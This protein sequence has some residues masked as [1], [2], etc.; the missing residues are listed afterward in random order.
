MKNSEETARRWLRQGEHNLNVT[1][2]LLNSGFWAGA[3]FYAE[4]TAK[5]VLKA[6]LYRRGQ[7]HIPIYSVRELALECAKEDDEFSVFVD[8]GGVLD[9]YYLSTRYPDAVADPA[10]PFET[11][12]E[13]EANRALESAR[14]IVDAVRAKVASD[15]ETSP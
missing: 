2:D 11:F 3:C 4:Q 5:L 6:F 14:A 10:V 12:S 7:R 1:L 13:E 9:R 8:S 15:T